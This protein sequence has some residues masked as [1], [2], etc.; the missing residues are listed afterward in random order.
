MCPILASA[1][2]NSR[3]QD[4]KSPRMAYRNADSI[5]ALGHL[6]G[7]RSKG[8]R[9]N[10]RID[11]A[12]SLYPHRSCLHLSR[13]LLVRYPLP[14]DCINERRQPL[15]AVA[16]Y[17]PLVQPKRE[18][19]DVPA[20]MLGGGMMI[21]PMQATLEN[22]PNRFDAVRVGRSARILAS[23]M[24]DGFVFVKQSIQIGENRVVVRVQL[25]TDFNAFKDLPLNRL[26][27]ADLYDLGSCT[28]AAFA[29]SKHG[30]FAN[31][32]TSGAEFLR[33]MLVGFETAYKALIDLDDAS[34]LG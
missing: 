9:D 33:F 30:S 2:H 10:P 24:I 17:V 4:P 27:G 28:S 18:L 25:G 19:I 26:D 3:N 22:C 23:R 11:P 16:L 8:N 1:D 31:R 13:K 5:P 20:K 12:L 14:D 21:N 32:T 6:Q 29:H 34:Q 7:H 15:K